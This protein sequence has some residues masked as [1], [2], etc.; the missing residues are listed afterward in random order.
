M[1]EIQKESPAGQYSPLALAYL[2][3]AVFSLL[4]RRHV[5]A[6]GNAPADKLHQKGRSLENAAAQAAMATRLEE[7]LTGEEQAILR[8]GRN[9]KTGSKAKNASLG[10]YH[11]ATGLEALFGYL[12]LSEREGRL[13][14]L[15]AIC[16]A[17]E[18]SQVL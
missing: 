14:E 3:D 9:A 16:V 18:E 8:R 17:R 10:D 15:F 12:Y 1:T 7:M 13:E 11:L 6:Q 5:L 2:G 4:A